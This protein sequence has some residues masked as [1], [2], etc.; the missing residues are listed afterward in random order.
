MTTK[1]GTGIENYC[2]RLTEISLAH[3]CRWILSPSSD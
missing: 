1:I 3:V 2:H